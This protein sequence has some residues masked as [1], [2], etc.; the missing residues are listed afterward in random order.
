MQPLAYRMRP[1]NLD[2]I[3]GHKKIIR[4]MVEAKLLSSMILYGPPGIG[5]TSIASAIA[6]STK[7]AFRKLNAATD[8]KKDLQIVAE[9][10]KMSGTVILLL[11][12]IHRLDKTKQDFLLPLLESGNII[13]IGAT[14]ENPYISISPAIRSRC[15]IFELHRLQSTDISRA[16]DRALNDSENGLGKYNVILTKDARNLLI[17]K[18]NGDLRSTLNALELAVL[19]TDQEK[20]DKSSDHKLIIDKNEIEDSIQFKAQ[21]Y[22]A[23]GDGHY[24]LLSAFQ[25]S[26][27]GSDTDAALYYLGNLCESGDLIAICRR[28]LVI[29]YEDIGLANPSACSRV[30]N[31]VQAAQMV[32]LPEAR[33]I[34]SNAVIELCL[35]PKSNSAITAIDSAIN[36]I[37]NKQNDSIPNN[38]KDAHYKG[39][40]K[41]NHGVSYIYPHDFKNDWVPQQYL[42]DNLKDASYFKPKGNSKIEDAL[43][44]QYLRLKKMQ[45]DGLKK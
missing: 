40:K 19:S 18:G 4:R 20:Q 21:N 28:L 9:E 33:I 7:Y 11:D 14:T 23:N 13:L 3:V 2:E 32:G 42:P 38:L 44:R 10:G 29:A 31:A 30:V 1:K 12:E 39:A 41:L 45:H 22:D 8:T 26:I 15:Q 37:R 6:G 27:R 34:L 36:D 5:K 24:D 35:S 25:K 17:D 16:I 43:K